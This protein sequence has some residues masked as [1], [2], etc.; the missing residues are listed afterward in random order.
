MAMENPSIYAAKAH[1]FILLLAEGHSQMQAL[2]EAGLPTPTKPHARFL[3]SI[4]SL[5]IAYEA[6]RVEY[7]Q[8]L[9]NLTPTS[10]RS[11]LEAL[12]FLAL[13]AKKYELS[14]DIN[15]EISK[16]LSLYPQPQIT[17]QQNLPVQINIIGVAALPSR[18]TLSLDST[19]IQEKQV[20][21]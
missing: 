8:E 14:L 19:L 9:A 2:Q 16:L 3:L 12:D 7:E 18:D 11:R 5:K 1:D 6:R 13:Q 4:P 10:M 17:A 21:N 15:K 20:L